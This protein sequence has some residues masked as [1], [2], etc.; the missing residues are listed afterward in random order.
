MIPY[1]LL[2]AYVL[3]CWLLHCRGVLGRGPFLVAFLVPAWALLAF[4]GSSVG[5]DTAMYLQMARVVDGLPWKDVLIPWGSIIWNMNEWGYGSTVDLGFLA[6]CK[7]VMGVAG[8]PQWVIAVCSA[9][10]CAGFGR[11]LYHCDEDVAQSMWCFLC[12]GLYMFAFS[13]MSQMVALAVAVQCLHLMHLGHWFRA[14]AFVLVALLFHVSALALLVAVVAARLLRLRR[15]Y[16]VLIGCSIAFPLLIGM[17]EPLVAAISP[18]Y[19]SYFQNNYW[20]AQIGG[21][22]LWWAVIAV[23]CFVVNRAGGFFRLASAPQHNMRRALPGPRSIGYTG[24]HSRASRALL[25]SLCMPT[26]TP[27]EVACLGE[28][29]LVVLL[30]RQ[31][32]FD[33]PLLQLRLFAGEVLHVLHLMLGGSHECLR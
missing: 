13:G 26:R 4:R 10:I 21:V 31:S 12:G 8:D 5:E 15:A 16:A 25:P 20:D 30:G 28:G 23:C 6:L 1:L 7:L 29:P 18:Q 11:F 24:L 2:A 3:F 17:A 33:C 27:G 22:V 32:R 14:V 19:A 9:I